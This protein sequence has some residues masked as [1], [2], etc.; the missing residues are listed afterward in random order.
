MKIVIDP[1]CHSVQSKHAKATLMENIEMAKSIGLDGLCITN[2]GPMYGDSPSEAYFEGLTRLPEK[3]GDFHIFSG[4]EV[5]ILD[6]K[7]T[8]DLSQECLSSLKWVI[9]SIHSVCFFNHNSDYITNAYINALKNPFIHCLGHIGQEKFPCDFNKIVKTAKK[10][11]KIIEINNSSLL[12][13]RKGA[14]TLCREV[15]KLCKEYGVKIVISSDA[16][17]K[18]DIGNFSEAIKLINE[19][20]FPENLII[21]SNLNKFT[22]YIIGG[23]LCIT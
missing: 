8:V 14:P 1:H 3:Y 16:H 12:G 23:K 18:E 22:T 10:L 6:D 17:E 13:M 15:L 20:S 9:A 21:N 4:A 11:N 19:I 2:H 5:N 7:G